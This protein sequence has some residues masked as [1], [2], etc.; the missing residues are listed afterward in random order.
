MCAKDSPVRTSTSVRPS[1]SEATTVTPSDYDL[2]AAC[3]KPSTWRPDWLAWRSKRSN[4]RTKPASSL[5]RI[6]TRKVEHNAEGYT[7]VANF[8][9]SDRNFLQYRGFFHLHSRLL[10][11]L[12]AD[13]VKL[14]SELDRMDRWDLDSGIEGRVMCLENKDRDD[15][16]SKMDKMPHAYL[17][18][19]RRTRPELLL[20][21]K[22]KLM[23]YDNVLLTTRKIHG[24]QRPSDRDYMAFIKRK[25]DLI[26][27]RDGRESAGFDGFVERCLR[28]ADYVLSRWC[29]CNIVGRIFTNAE[30]RN[31]S[32]D[33]RMYHYAP[34][35]IDM[36]VNLIITTII[37]VLLI[38][39]VVLMYTL[40]GLGGGASPFEA[41]GILI[42][43]TLLFGLSMSLLT[44]AKRQE[45][46]AASAAYCAVLVVFVSNFGVQSV[47][48]VKA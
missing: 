48:I 5:G 36:L 12:Q 45:L 42:A 41:L 37:F 15:L 35:R 3:E 23:E 33:L 13:I 4:E 43:F 1:L 24:L 20:E 32:D 11:I 18:A 28:G 8:Q 2:E 39:P 30:L 17:V 29:H 9:S 22:A 38:V 46:F 7:L 16:E 27:L 31:K 40:S 47:Q 26:T 19:F 44:T 10:S 25:E 14:E 6:V 34:Q 21:L